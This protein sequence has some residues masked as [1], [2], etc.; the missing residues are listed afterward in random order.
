MARTYPYRLSC[1]PFNAISIS[2]FG[3]GNPIHLGVEVKGSIHGLIQCYGIVTSKIKGWRTYEV[4]ID[5]YSCR[6]KI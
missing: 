4:I 2:I 5:L 1:G 6:F 3:D